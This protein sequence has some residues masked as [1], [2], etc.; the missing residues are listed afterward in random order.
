MD[1]SILNCL[2]E[3]D[4][5]KVYI[6]MGLTAFVWGTK[7][8]C[9][10][11]FGPPVPEPTEPPKAPRSIECQL[12]LDALAL[13]GN[14]VT[15]EAGSNK[16]TWDCRVGARTLS[17]EPLT[18]Y[19]NEPDEL[20]QIF[21]AS[22]EIKNLTEEDL[23]E[24]EH[25]AREHVESIAKATEARRREAI[26]QSLGRDTAAQ[27]MVSGVTVNEIRGPASG[28]CQVNTSPWNYNAFN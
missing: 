21:V 4:A 5:I 13:P 22:T 14:P 26:L 15:Y 7:Y 16:T 24:I 19:I 3:A 28:P 18:I 11:L 1:F 6:G 23:C 8:V 9:H 12:I 27:A 2:L 17:G 20:I 25:E 10:R